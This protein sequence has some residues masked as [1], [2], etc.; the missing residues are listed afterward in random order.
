MQSRVLPSSS[1]DFVSFVLPQR[2]TVCQATTPSPA[3]SASPCRF[4]PAVLWPQSHRCL[5][6]CR[7]RRADRW[8]D[9]R[10]HSRNGRR[11][12]SCAWKI[13][14]H[15]TATPKKRILPQ[16]VEKNSWQLNDP[17]LP[18]YLCAADCSVHLWGPKIKLQTGSTRTINCKKTRNPLEIHEKK[19][20][21]KTHSNKNTFKQNKKKQTVCKSFKIRQNPIWE[22]QHLDFSNFY[23]SECHLSTQR[24]QVFRRTEKEAISRKQLW[25]LVQRDMGHGKWMEIKT[26]YWIKLNPWLETS[27]LF[28]WTEQF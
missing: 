25:D 26:F 18:T 10:R 2:V 17:G 8:D 3:S 5:R 14:P 20:R 1:Q 15:P 13:L 12:P 6:R 4:A 16:I 21:N 28:L 11:T 7:R 19:T 9:P 23:R 22:T 27:Q 24:C